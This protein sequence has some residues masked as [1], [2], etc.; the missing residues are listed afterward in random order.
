MPPFELNPASFMASLRE[1]Q[2]GGH[3]TGF[4]PHLWSTYAKWVKRLS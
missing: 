2:P 4:V 1:A 3:L